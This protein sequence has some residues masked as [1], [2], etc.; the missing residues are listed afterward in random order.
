MGD[1]SSAEWQELVAAAASAATC[2]SSWGRYCLPGDAVKKRTETD[3][4]APAVAL[5]CC[6][7]ADDIRRTIDDLDRMTRDAGDLDE[8][9]DAWLGVKAVD[10]SQL[11]PR[12]SV[13]LPWLAVGEHICLVGIVSASL[14]PEQPI[15][16]GGT[17]GVLFRMTIHAAMP[18]V[19]DLARLGEMEFVLPRDSCFL[20]LAIHESVGVE[21]SQ[22]NIWYRPVIEVEQV[23]GRT[24]E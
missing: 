15:F 16:A 19:G 6:S 24:R 3:A 17:D 13:L 2:G 9:I 8:P 14:M 21:D 18:M 7:I 4:L 1:R 22:G 12:D 20:I 10:V 11:A 5:E 23:C